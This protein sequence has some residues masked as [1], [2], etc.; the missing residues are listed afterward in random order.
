[1]IR[2]ISRPATR[3]GIAFLALAT[4]AS[5]LALRDVKLDS[6]SPE[7][8]LD[9]RLD[10][11]MFDFEAQL[12]DEQGLLAMTIE[13]P[14]FRHGANSRIGT[15]SNPTVFLLESGNEWTIEAGS[16]VITADQDFVSLAGN[17]KMVRKSPLTCDFLQ[18]DTR[19]MVIE[20]EPRTA[21]TES[22]VTMRHARDRLVATGM[23]LDMAGNRYELLGDV[24]AVYDT[25]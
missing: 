2:F 10:Y 5:Y 22:Q 8:E 17:V 16:A 4:V 9:T 18:I 3:R 23:N 19:D 7:S 12:L 11:A 25:P 13:A 20:V 1:M 6:A 14:L 24:H 21:T 15:I